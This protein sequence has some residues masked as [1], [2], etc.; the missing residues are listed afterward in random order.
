MRVY[1]C[2]Q[3]WTDSHEEMWM[4]LPATPWELVDA[5]ER[6]GLS[7]EAD[8]YVQAEEYYDFDYI[9]SFIP[10]STTLSQLNEL[11]GILRQG[12]QRLQEHDAGQK[13]G[14]IINKPLLFRGCRTGGYRDED[15]ENHIPIYK[16]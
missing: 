9:Q 11:C 16:K 1:L 2:G 12:K 13:P 10:D 14:F 6:L 5:M 15:K 3:D 7:S 8:L 4:D